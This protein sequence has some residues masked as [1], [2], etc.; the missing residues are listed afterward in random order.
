AGRLVFGGDT[1]SPELALALG[2]VDEVVPPDE[3]LDRA[4]AVANR[5]ATAIPADSFA[6]SKTQLRRESLERIARYRVD[7]DPK[8]EELWNRRRDDG[9]TE[10]YLGSVTGKG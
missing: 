10:R 5:L 9:W 4:L 8:A 6:M 3:L 1:V 7:E 2:L